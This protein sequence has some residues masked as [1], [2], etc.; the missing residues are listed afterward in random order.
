M[1][2]ESLQKRPSCG[3]TAKRLIGGGIGIIVKGS[4][5][6]RGAWRAKTCC[7]KAERCSESPCSDDG[8]CKR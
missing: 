3:E 4:G 2:D 7:G 1:S 8:I 5:L 6:R